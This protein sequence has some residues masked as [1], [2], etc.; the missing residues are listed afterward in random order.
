MKNTLFNTGKLGNLNTTN[1]VVMAPMTRSRTAQPGDIPTDLMATYYAQ[2]ASAGFIVSEA[3]QISSQGKGYSFT[4]GIYTQAQIDGWKKVTDAV[5]KSSGIIF[6]QL[7]HVGRMSHPVFH[8]DGLPVAPSALAPDAQVW[9]VGDDGVGRMLDCPIPRALSTQEIKGIVED[10][11][12][13]AVNAIEAGFDGV[14][15]HAGNG[16]LIDQF[17]RSTSNKRTDEYGGSLENRIKFALDI[18][19][20]IS[21]EIGAERTA[22]RLAP[23]ITQRGMNDPEAIDAILLL[24]KHFDE[25]GIAY[26]HLA[27]ADWDDAPKVTPAFRQQLRENFS[28]AIVVAGNY[29]PE[30]SD[31]LIGDGLVDFVAFGRKFL[32]NPDLPYRLENNLP[33]ND[34]SDQATLFGGDERGYTDYPIYCK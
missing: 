23:F 4:P 6:S 31:E 24:A 32:A 5:H 10:Y 2:R 16:Y 21:D 20:A 22:I 33:L 34:I 13:G 1:K 19:K 9:V 25:L 26:I 18:I 28:G 15:V 8:P 27:E 30:K 17:L 3:T 14:E 11:R 29:T 12:Q 7:W